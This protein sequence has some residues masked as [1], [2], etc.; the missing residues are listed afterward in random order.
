[1][2]DPKLEYIISGCKQGLAPCQKALVQ[3]YSGFL[4]SICLRYIGD[5]TKSK[6]VLQDAFIRIFKYIKSFDADKGSIK[7]WMSKILVNTALKH[8]NREGLKNSTLTIDFNDKVSVEPSI[9]SKMAT[10]DLLELV[11]SLPEGYRQ[12][13]NLSVIEGYSHKEIAALLKIKEVSSRSNLS[14]AKQ[15]L[16][17]KLLA[18]KNSESWARRI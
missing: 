16:R 15:I 6:D 3:R 10:D 12:V 4:Y 8:I 9:L 14:R 7:A 17:T 2:P 13:F 18:F 1:M 5:E 11:R